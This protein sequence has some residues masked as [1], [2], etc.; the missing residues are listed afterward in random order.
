M[1]TLV[2]VVLSVTV[3]FW[4]TSTLLV[5]IEIILPVD[6]FNSRLLSVTVVLIVLPLIV[7]SPV[8]NVPA[9]VVPNTVVKLPVL[10]L[11]LTVKSLLTNT[12]V[13]C[14]LTIPEPFAPNLRSPST[15]VVDN[16][17]VLMLKSLNQKYI[18]FLYQQFIKH[19]KLIPIHI[20]L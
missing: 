18:H 8:V 9:V 5:G 16:V 4:L 2:T 20:L 1:L 11:R 3:N 6:A 10:I 7:I 19:V 13:V 12:F 14:T 17:F 15:V